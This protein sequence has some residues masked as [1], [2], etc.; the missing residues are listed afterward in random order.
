GPGEN[1]GT[2]LLATDS[3]PF[4]SSFEKLLAAVVFHWHAAH[5]ASVFTTHLLTLSLS[6]GGSHRSARPSICTVS[7]QQQ[8]PCGLRRS[9][10]PMQTASSRIPSR[11]I[12]TNTSP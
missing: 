8:S 4:P 3:R 11:R 1:I 10:G 7:I 12:R 9:S 5:F 2:A 6:S